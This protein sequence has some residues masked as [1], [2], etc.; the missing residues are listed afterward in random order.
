MPSWR[1]APTQCSSRL[2]A[3]RIPWCRRAPQVPAKMSL[4]NFTAPPVAI[5]GA[6]GASSAVCAA[7][8]GLGGPVG[9]CAAV[10]VHQQRYYST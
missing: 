5:L 10:T 1:P 7:M 3:V 4:A 2:A 8:P 9:G 6:D